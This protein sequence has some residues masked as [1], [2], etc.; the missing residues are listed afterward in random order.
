M[1]WIINAYNI[2]GKSLLLEKPRLWLSLLCLGSIPPPPPPPTP[3]SSYSCSSY[4]SCSTP[5]SFSSSS[6]FTASSP[7]PRLLQPAPHPL[8]EP[9]E[10]RQVIFFLQNQ[11]HNLFNSMELFYINKKMG[12][13]MWKSELEWHYLW[14]GQLTSQCSERDDGARLWLRLRPEGEKQGRLDRRCRGEF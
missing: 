9:P 10:D 8:P 3:P 5:F 14:K 4:S 12:T 1:C 7:H 6:S 13:G 11:D 2:C